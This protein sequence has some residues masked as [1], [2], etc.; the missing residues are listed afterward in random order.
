MSSILTRL[1]NENNESSNPMANN[2][3]DAGGQGTAGLSS[4]VLFSVASG[5]FP[6]FA[7][8][9]RG[10]LMICTGT[11]IAPLSTLVNYI[12]NNPADNTYIKFLYITNATDSANDYGLEVLEDLKRLQKGTKQFDVIT[13]KTQPRVDY[14][15]VGKLVQEGIDSNNF[16]TG[17][18]GVQVH[19]SGNPEFVKKLYLSSLESKMM[20]LRPEQVVG[21]GYSDR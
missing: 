5:R 6:Y 14:L 12:L 17:D 16:G 3:T 4:G 8:N 11:G 10:L 2:K 7:N 20:N 18:K 15:M 21:W 19:L 9:Y 13:Q 1:A